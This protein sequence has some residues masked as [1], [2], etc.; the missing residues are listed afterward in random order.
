MASLSTTRTTE[1]SLLGLC[2]HYLNKHVLLWWCGG[3][4]SIYTSLSYLTDALRFV[5]RTTIKFFG[6][7]FSWSH[8]FSANVC[9]QSK[10]VVLECVKLDR[11]SRK[12]YIGRLLLLPSVSAYRWGLTLLLSSRVFAPKCAS[13]KQPILPAQ[14]TPHS[15]GRVRP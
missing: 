14:V 6:F 1:H 5:C 11:N 12:Q 13:C 4:Q 2:W 9:F 15:V 8:D 3:P 10:L 7:F